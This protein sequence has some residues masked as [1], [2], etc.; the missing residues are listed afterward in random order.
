[1]A[2][3]ASVLCLSHLRWN[4]VDQ[5]PQQLLSRCALERTVV[6][7]ED[8]VFDA[9]APAL[10]LSK[11]DEG[12]VVAVPHLPPSMPPNQVEAA[13][14]RMIDR[15]LAENG[16]PT[17]VLWYYT[18]MA[19]GFTDHVKA[20]AIVYDC[21]DPFALAHGAPLELTQREVS[22]FER[23]DVV[24]IDGY[25][26]YR[27]KRRT[28]AHRNI[29]AFPSNVDLAHFERARDIDMFDPPDQAEIER[30]RVG[31]FGVIDERIDL[32][33]LGDLAELRPDLQFVM[34]GPIVKLDPATLPQQPNVHWLGAKAHAALPAYLACWDVA[35]MPFA[36]N[37]TTRFISSTKTLEY[38]A[39]GKP[40]V[41]T[42]VPDVVNPYGREGLV[43]LADG[44]GEFGD[45]IDEALA[46]DRDAR[47]A[48]ADAFLDG[49][50]W[51][52]TWREMWALV[53]H[54]IST[55]K[56]V[57]TPSLWPPASRSVTRGRATQASGSP[58]KHSD[59]RLAARG[60]R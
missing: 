6:F 20:S 57:R 39:A 4:F 60:P 5:R 26:L 52:R 46:S 28:V 36:C 7:F 15:V 38:L 55:Q 42:W 32:E 24:F 47:L 59:A 33:M 44:A 9:S 40:V 10:E 30:P 25:S 35:M 50:S 18:P 37:D 31:F 22:L 49:L 23:A 27:H 12:V 2:T 13:L 53:E 1:M 58:N 19:L 41:S 48:H 34:I 8:P 17:P 29:H 56:I 3:R 51:D 16:D 45:A 11:S 21:T 43:W 54:V 14:R